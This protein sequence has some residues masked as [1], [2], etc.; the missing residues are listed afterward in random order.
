MRCD[1]QFGVGDQHA[2]PRSAHPAGRHTL[3]LSALLGY[4]GAVAIC[5]A[6]A[7]LA[8]ALHWVLDTASLVLMFLLAVVLTAAR[9]G[10][11]PASLA[12]ALAVL[13]FNLMFVPPRYSFAVADEQFFFTFAVMLSV[14]LLVGQLT[15]GLRAQAEAARAREQQVRSLYDISRELGGALTAQ[16]VAEALTRFARAEL[17]A[18]ATLWVRSGSEALQVFGADPG[19][20]E[21]QRAAALMGTSLPGRAPTY[22]AQGRWCLL[23]LEATMAV[24][25]AVAV[26]RED[27]PG[28]WLDDERQLLQTCAHLLAGA[29][30]RIHYL[31][32]AQASAVE[33]EG[34][35]LRNVLL[36]AVSHDLRTP[37]ASLIG[38]A[39]S[40]ELT[41]PAPSAQQRE[42]AAAV[43]ASARRMGVLVDNLLEMARLQSG[44]V[45]LNLQWQ[46][47]EEVV[48]TAVAAVPGLAERP[49]RIAMPADLPLVHFDAVLME[50]VLVNLLENAVKY[51]PDATPIEIDA[52]MGAEWLHLAVYD[53]GPGVLASR[54][55][56]IF[57]M[58]ERGQREGATPGVG[59]GLALCRMIVEAH[60]GTLHSAQREGGGAAFEVRLPR[61]VPPLVPDETCDP[62]ADA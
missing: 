49:L 50:R 29:L 39:E 17:A 23:P 60:G 12:S 47:I 4:V 14:G 26:R 20:E 32:V 22:D 58:F 62:E 7:G 3:S 31:E 13:L 43:A 41:R 33:I 34:E 21:P 19:G 24:R 55:H 46:P 52:R 10:R 5:L 44:R 56:D 37:L 30:E 48:G 9:F 35:R 61:G 57:R 51:T 2:S 1:L 25:G 27:A 45:Q 18:E 38:L 42:I 36:A 53:E 11:G 28:S 54:S 6:A 8:W 59:L 40:L 15:A 16:Q